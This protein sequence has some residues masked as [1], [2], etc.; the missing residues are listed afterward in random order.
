MGRRSLHL[1]L[2]NGKWHAVGTVTTVDGEVIRIRK[3][4]G[5]S[6]DEKSYAQAKLVTMANEAIEASET[7]V[8]RTFTVW[9][10]VDLYLDRPN[11]AGETD[12]RI[13]KNFGK[14][15]GRKHVKRLDLVQV[16][17]WFR[18]RGIAAST[19]ARE[20]TSINSML[21][22]AKEFGVDVPSKYLKK[23]SVDDARTRWIAPDARDKLIKVI[24]PDAQSFLTFL[25]FMGCRLGE[26]GKLTW[27]NVLEDACLFTSYKGKERKGKTRRVP[28]GKTVKSVMGKRRMN[29]DAPV[30]RDRNGQQW[31]RDSF[32]KVFRAA[33]MELG[34]EDFRPHDCRHTYASLLAQKGA[35]LNALA[36]LLGHSR[37]DMVM[38]YAHLSPSHLGTTVGLLEDD[39][40]EDDTDMTRHYEG[41]VEA[42]SSDKASGAVSTGV[43]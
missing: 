35:S 22:Y 39:G 41:L 23:P 29:P 5:Y 12:Q 1:R 18:S 31:T 16:A 7:V 28:M 4:T 3:S 14:E 20:I 21:N 8:P 32:G 42:G 33:C 11:P 36:E 13:L 6:K 40:V 15:F 25:F 37:I 34:L 38:R 17:E 43:S 2:R 30:F 26:A 19:V 24:R 9:Q 27:G 10:C